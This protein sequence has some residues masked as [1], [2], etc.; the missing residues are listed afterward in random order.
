MLTP[1]SLGL[2]PSPQIPCHARGPL[3]YFARLAETWG[4]GIRRMRGAL[5]DAGLPPPEFRDE[6]AWLRLTFYSAEPEPVLA[7]PPHQLL[8]Q[9]QR[10]TRLTGVISRGLNPRQRDLLAAWEE[11]GQGQI[12][13]AEY[14]RR[15]D[16]AVSTAAK[17]LQ[18]LVAWGLAWPVGKG[19]QTLYMYVG[20][21]G[22]SASFDQAEDAA[23]IEDRR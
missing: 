9:H 14:E 7:R 4:T 13:R 2:H 21:A 1:R 10:A 3:A 22:A 5:L 12:R 23:E 15:F 8:G 17:D 19:P 16:I 20:T 6:D 18:Q 11:T